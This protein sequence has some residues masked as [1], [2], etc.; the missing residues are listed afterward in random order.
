[1]RLISSFI[2]VC[3]LTGLSLANTTTAAIESYLIKMFNY[4]N[5]HNVKALE[6]MQGEIVS[7]KIGTIV[8]AYSLAL[9]IASPEKYKNQYVDNFPVTYEGIMYDLYELIELKKFTPKFL[10]SIESIGLIAQDGNDKAIE[11]VLEGTIHSDGVVSDSFCDILTGLFH[12]QPQ[13]TL[14]ALS[15]LN[16]EQRSKEYSCFKLMDSEEF[17]I[18]KEYIEKLKPATTLEKKVIQEIMQYHYCPNVI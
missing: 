4:A 14:K 17:V 15:K 12:K 18:L 11:K 5:A 10:Y 13:K 6:D 16:A 3:I 9:Y 8:T 7:K 2:L 1:M